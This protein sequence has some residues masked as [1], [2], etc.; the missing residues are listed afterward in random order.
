MYPSEDTSTLVVRRLIFPGPYFL[1]IAGDVIY[2]KEKSEA[3]LVVQL[4][5]ALDS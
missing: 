1:R 5:R 2:A 4:P 3:R